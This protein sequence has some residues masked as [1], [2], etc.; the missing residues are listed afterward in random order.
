MLWPVVTQVVLSALF[1]QP[2]ADVNPGVVTQ[3]PCLLDLLLRGPFRAAVQVVCRLAGVAL[4]GSQDNHQDDSAKEYQSSRRRGPHELPREIGD[5]WEPRVP[6]DDFPRPVNAM[7]MN[8][9]VHGIFH[10]QGKD[11]RGAH[12]TGQNGDEENNDPHPP[13]DNGFDL[14][15]LRGVGVVASLHAAIFPVPVLLPSLVPQ[16]W[17]VLRRAGC[18]GASHTGTG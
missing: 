8:S 1:V 17:R 16:P 5:G 9:K 18:P 13:A 15:D 7:K 6:F 14:V 4:E 11:L 3:K 10:A 2:R 12:Q